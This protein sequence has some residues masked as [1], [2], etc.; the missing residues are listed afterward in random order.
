[1]LK[2]ARMALK[3]AN[4]CRDNLWKYATVA[5]ANMYIGKMKQAKKFYAKAAK[6]AGVRQ[7]ISIH[8]NAYTGYTSVMQM[9][10]P[11]D[12]FIK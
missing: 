2:Y 1:M 10:N 4:K 8:T 11:N 3:S 5:E 12:K 9:D 6:M 7:K